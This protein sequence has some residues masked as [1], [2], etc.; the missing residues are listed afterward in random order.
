M[1][2]LGYLLVKKLQHLFP[3]T[4]EMLLL[5][6]VRLT[7][8]QPHVCANS[9]DQ[10]W[11]PAPGLG[12]H[13][14]PASMERLGLRLEAGSSSDGPQA[15]SAARS[16]PNRNGIHPNES[17]SYKYVLPLFTARFLP[18]SPIEHCGQQVLSLSPP[19]EK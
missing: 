17:H 3:V 16:V 1:P 7:A 4:L 6:R 8:D 2:P 18:V 9:S 14:N 12:S 19:G 5:Q 15:A 11:K 13:L 10:S